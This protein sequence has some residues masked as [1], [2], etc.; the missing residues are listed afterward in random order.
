MESTNNRRYLFLIAGLI[1]LSLLGLGIKR[2]FFSKPTLVT[3]VGEGKVTAEPT[4][5]KFVV[6][7]TA[8][9]NSA[10]EAINEEKRIFSETMSVLRR[11]GIK[12]GDTKSSYLRVDPLTV[13]G[14]QASQG[15]SVTLT[16]VNRF[17]FS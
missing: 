9:G 16:Q 8:R 6:L 14:Y 10:A 17:Q 4:E 2:V 5:A 12:Q 3:V 15:I 1:L 13:G 7:L 11:Y